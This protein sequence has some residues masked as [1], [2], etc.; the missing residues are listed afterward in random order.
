MK[1]WMRAG[2]HKRWAQS[3]VVSSYN[4]LCTVPSSVLAPDYQLYFDLVGVKTYHAL[5][6]IASLVVVLRGRFD[7][8]VRQLRQFEVAS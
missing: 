5:D 1:T 7:A 4:M 8:I 3:H 2:K 6:P